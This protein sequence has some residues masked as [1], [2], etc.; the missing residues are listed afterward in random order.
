M[1]NID[2]AIELLELSPKKSNGIKLIINI[3]SLRR[4][5]K[6]EFKNIEME[7]GIKHASELDKINNVD[8]E[9]TNKG[10][11]VNSYNDYIDVEER[12][13]YINNTPIIYLIAN[14]YDERILCESMELRILK[15]FDGNTYFIKAEYFTL[16][17][18]V[19]GVLP[20][21]MVNYDGSISSI[22]GSAYENFQY[23]KGRFKTKKA[24][25]IGWM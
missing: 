7:K 2:S 12:N 6:R 20:N 24:V 3:D 15:G 14:Q 1:N 16:K 25:K 11:I 9:I 19:Y 21:Y 5:I 13:G 10:I 4:I 23:I 8:G 22:P 17:G 18:K